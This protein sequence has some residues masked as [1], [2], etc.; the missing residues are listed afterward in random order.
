[1]EP[2]MPKVQRE[3]RL[4]CA[5]VVRGAFDAQVVPAYAAA[6]GSVAIDWAPTAV[7]LETIAAGG[8]AD[9]VLVLSGAMDRLTAEGRVEAASRVDVAR[10]RYGLGA[11]CSYPG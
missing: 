3:T 10:S 5:L 7:I 2:A 1:M 9:A 8:T 11:C 4:M 6:G